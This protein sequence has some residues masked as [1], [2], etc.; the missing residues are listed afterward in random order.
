MFYQYTVCQKEAFFFS[1]HNKDAGLWPA[2]R[3]KTAKE[4]KKKK[5]A[6]R[7]SRKSLGQRSVE[8]GRRGGF[9]NEEHMF[10][11]ETPPGADICTQ[12]AMEMKDELLKGPHV[13]VKET[14]WL[15]L[16]QVS[17]V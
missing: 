7:L 14:G 17:A 13:A 4:R 2:F 9:N 11:R 12:A 16:L 6:A 15:T 10:H 5:K 8:D 1:S 3:K